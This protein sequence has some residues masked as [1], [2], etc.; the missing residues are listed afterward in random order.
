MNRKLATAFATSL[1]ACFFIPQLHAA[2]GLYLGAG[3]GQAGIKDNI[4]TGNFDAN[5]AAYKAFI[6]WRFK[7]PVVAPPIVVSA[8]QL[9]APPL[10]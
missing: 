3:I 9:I 5:D 10:P 7:V 4:N 6:G 1:L 2:D 8:L